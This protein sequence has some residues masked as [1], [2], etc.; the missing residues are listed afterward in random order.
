METHFSNEKIPVL[1]PMFRFQWEPAQNCF[2]LL[3][4]EGMVKLS[5]SAGE[6]IKRCD[7]KTD[8]RGI[9]DDLTQQFPDVD[10]TTDTRNFLE[11]AYAK[12]WLKAK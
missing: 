6:I 2:V 8:V 11:T 9:I 4:P 3:Y 10:V 12:G 1:A 5:T 7:G